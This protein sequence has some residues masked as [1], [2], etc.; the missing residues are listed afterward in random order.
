MPALSEEVIAEL[1][2][3]VQ[4]YVDSKHDLENPRYLTSGGS[5]AIFE[6]SK[7]GERR[8][9]K[10]YNTSLFSGNGREAELRRLRLQS[11]LIGHTC[12]NLVAFYSVEEAFGTA[13][14]EMEFIPWPTLKDIL[15][16]FPDD[17]IVPVLRKL[18]SAVRY[19]GQR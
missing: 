15:S 16:E 13:F 8:A 12:E 1:T 2:Q 9:I 3:R 14:L 10:V 17:A 6:V 7:A 18:V 19:L 11:E 4:S 5:A